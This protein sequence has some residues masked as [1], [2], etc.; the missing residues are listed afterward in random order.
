MSAPPDVTLCIRRVFR[1]LFSRSAADLD[2]VALPHPANAAIL[3]KLPTSDDLDEHLD[4]LQVHVINEHPGPP[5]RMLVHPYFRGSIMPLTLVRTP[6]GLKAD[7]RWWLIAAQGP[8]EL[9]QTARAFTFAIISGD[10]ELLARTAHVK[11]VAPETLA[12]LTRR[13]APGGE[14]GQYEHVCQEMPMRELSVGEEFPWPPEG[15]RT[16]RPEDAS[17]HRRILMAQFGG[18]EFTYLLTRDPS[19]PGS[20]WRVDPTPFLIAASMGWVPR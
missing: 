13:P 6:E 20:P 1:A 16:V 14:L 17:E 11:N 12:L 9:D 19:E 18:D 4:R 8:T 2:Q 5:P 10:E 7:L 3:A 15:L